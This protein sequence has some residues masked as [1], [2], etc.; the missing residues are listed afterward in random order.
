MIKILNLKLVIFLEYQIKNI[1]AKDY[2]PSWFEEVFIIKNVENTVLWTYAI[3]DF[4][5]EEIVG[6]V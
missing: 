5:D 2:V 1:S 6:T 3:N 4:K